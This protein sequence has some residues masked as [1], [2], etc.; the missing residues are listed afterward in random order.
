MQDL[1]SVIVPVYKVEKYLKRCV[2]S[3]LAQTYPC[4]EVI[5]VDDGSP[6]GCPAICDEY[7]REDRRV[8][9]IHKENG[10]LSDAR[11]AGIDAAKGN[12]LGFIRPAIWKLFGPYLNSADSFLS[13]P[14]SQLN[15]TLTHGH[16]RD[17]C[18]QVQVSKANGPA[19]Q[20]RTDSCLCLL[21]L[22]LVQRVCV[23]TDK[24]TS[25]QAKPQP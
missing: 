8:R 5:L 12:F 2:D 19:G 20:H 10:G 1:I 13:R 14:T 15:S 11:N 4:L 9:V 16:V 25:R 7:A 6:D 18:G 3:I 17:P 23:W 24:A 21:L 22:S